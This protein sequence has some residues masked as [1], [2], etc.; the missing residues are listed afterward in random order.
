MLRLHLLRHGQTAASRENVFCGSGS[1]VA[2]TA[3]GVAMADAFALAYRDTVWRAVYSS[4]LQRAIAT[5]QATAQQCGVGVTVDPALAEI[6]YGAWDGLQADAVDRDDHDAFVR[7]TADPAWHAP[8][9]GE[10]AVALARRMLGVVERIRRESP[11]GDVLVVSHKASIRTLLCA[12]LGIDVGRFRSRFGCPVASVS[13]VE[14]TDR[15]PLA[16]TIADRSHLDA[17]LRGLPGT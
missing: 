16:Q 9:G 3:D 11:D 13:V 5:A 2:L 8:T 15:G 14:F 7:W 4:P 10:T 17:R 1:D 12:L 6:D